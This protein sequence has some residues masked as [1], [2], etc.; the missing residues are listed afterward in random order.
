MPSKIEDYAIVGNCRT[1]ALIGRDGSV[2]WMCLPRFDSGACFAALLGD[3]SHGRWQIAPQGD[4]ARVTRRYRDRTLVLETDFELKNGDCVRIIDFMPPG[5]GVTEL[6]R[7]VEGVRGR[8]PMQLEYILRL[9]YG[10]VIPWVQ[11][12]SRGIRAVAGPDKVYLR[13]QIPVRG[14]A[15]STVAEFTIGPGEHLSMTLTHTSTISSRPPLL[16]ARQSLADTEDFWRKWSKDF[17]CE[18]PWQEE[19]LRSLITL[20]ALT[21]QP[22]GGVVA[23]VTTS[24]PEHLGG[25]RNWDYRFCWL[26]DATF[27][28]MAFM[29]H[30]FVDEAVAWRRW[31]VNAVAGSPSKA[32]IM[33][34]IA[35]ERR[36]TE[37]AL[38]WLPG[39]EGSRPVRIGNGA[40]SQHQLDVYGEVMDAM[41]LARKAGIEPED[42]AWELQINLMKFL[43]TDWQHPDEGIWEVRG[44]RRHFVHSKVM[45][46]VAADRAVRAVEQFGASGDVE[47]WSKLRDT[48][49]A[50]VCEKGFDPDLN[51]FVQSYGS[52]EADASLLMLPLV[53]FIDAN[54]PRML[55]TVDYIKRKLYRNGFVHRYDTASGG[56]GLP[57][58]EGT[59][60]LCTFWLAD[61]LIL[62][63]KK[64]EAREIFERLLS[65]RNDVGLL[66]EEYDPASGRMLGNFPQ[67]FSHVGLINTARNLADDGQLLKEDRERDAKTKSGTTSGGRSAGFLGRVV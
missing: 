21:Y 18:H 45:A 10:S 41:H 17:K 40:Y 35:G 49:H 37:I 63:G 53:G 44:P 42:T 39:Y 46:W 48:I 47:G 36:L 61:N 60:L 15:M 51:S 16:D 27:T 24:L 3:A 38:D 64:H 8:V 22:T 57:G 1:A 54:D 26:R 55:G 67:A 56:D 43:E 30:G 58:S 59:F 52:S 31:L 28:L 20:K 32:Q 6:V 5:N 66:A 23:A 50:E 29:S 2:D 25:V 65:L 62:Q 9:D 14:E 33:Y 13:G 19:T 12:I 4:V 7:I 11:H 34:G